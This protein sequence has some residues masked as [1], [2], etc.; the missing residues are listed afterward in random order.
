MTTALDNPDFTAPEDAYWGFF[1]AD[2]AKN[3]VAW[4]NVM[5]YPH[6]RVSARGRFHYFDTPEEYAARADWTA[7]EA[8]GWVRSQGRDPV[9]LH[10][11]ADK[12][13]LLGGW[14]RYNADNEPILSNHVTYILTKPGDFWGIQ[15]RFAT[16]SFS[17]S[18]DGEAAN[19]ATALVRQFSDDLKHGNLAACARLCRYPF[20]QVGIGEV[21]RIE[22]AAGLQEMLGDA[23]ARTRTSV[24]VQAAKSATHGVIVTVTTAYETGD[25]EHTLMIVGKQESSWQIAGASTMVASP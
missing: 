6:V 7:R 24:D 18:D 2:S 19:A 10:E 1:R 16:E 11:S 9:R 8:P 20:V 17:G 3:A 14:T 12:V 22:D 5:S 23:P 25:S 13:H 15:A 4:A 21:R